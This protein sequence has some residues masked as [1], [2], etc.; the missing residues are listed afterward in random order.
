M[1]FAEKLIPD[2][3]I[4]SVLDVDGIRSKI[5]FFHIFNSPIKTD[6][7]TERQL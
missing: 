3:E 2:L 4:V 1:N 7:I 6:G 5:I